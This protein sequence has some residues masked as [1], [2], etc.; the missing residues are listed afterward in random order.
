VLVSPAPASKPASG[1]L[2]IGRV[3]VCVGCGYSLRGLSLQDRCP[4]CGRE[5]GPAFD[6]GLLHFAELG[7]LRRCRAATLLLLAAA[8]M[9]ALIAS[10][11]LLA[12]RFVV[13]GTIAYFVKQTGWVVGSLSPVLVVCGVGLLSYRNPTRGTRFAAGCLGLAILT[14]PAILLLN[15]PVGSAGALLLLAGR[16]VFLIGWLLMVVQTLRVLA[17]M[18]GRAA[19]PDRTAAG[20]RTA[21]ILLCGVGLSLIAAQLLRG[22]GLMFITESPASIAPGFVQ[23]ILGWAHRLTSI[24]SVAGVAVLLGLLP[25]LWVTWRTLNRSVWLAERT[26]L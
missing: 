22:I 15:F 25:A 6:A 12:T 24:G 14:L 26:R 13:S 11:S 18:V 8:A 10:A 21:S 5:A 4:E 9:Q 2:P 3:P 7:L 20:L 17:Y 16:A 19:E 1:R 23:A